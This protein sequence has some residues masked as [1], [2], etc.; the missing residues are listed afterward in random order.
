MRRLLSAAVLCLAAWML[1]AGPI[2][3]AAETAALSGGVQP[4]TATPFGA[5]SPT[6]PPPI[7]AGYGSGPVAWVLATQSALHRDLAQAILR[8]K[9]ER[10][11]SAALA[12]ALLSFGY[13]VLHAVGP[14]HGKAVISSYVLGNEQTIR[15]GVALSFA[16]ALVQALAAILLVG[17][18]ALLLN[19]AGFKIQAWSNRL[20]TASYA[21]IMAVGAW[22]LF[23]QVRTFLARRAAAAPHAP[24]RGRAHDDHGHAHSAPVACRHDHH[25]HHDRHDGCGH[26]H[27]PDPRL[28]AGP[29]SLKKMAAIVLA[30]GIRPCTGAILVLIFALAQGLFWAGVAATF[31]MALGTAITVSAL[32]A[33]AVGS[34]QLALRFANG[35]GGWTE[36][37]WAVCGIGG[38]AMVLMLGAILFVASL[39]PAR[40]L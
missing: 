31:A 23:T 8:F 3:A 37:I 20:E 16:A 9:S 15:R 19:M 26:A 33:L 22:L 4:R 11:A 2:A 36:T 10:A 18:M 21:L 27:M 7:S 14:G 29:V 34:R 25:D 35:S 39:G 24:D 40:P 30:V 5:P 32:A 38:S 6:G 1:I 17:V 13:G 28:L 12:L